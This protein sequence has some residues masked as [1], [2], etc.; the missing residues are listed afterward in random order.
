MAMLNK[1]VVNVSMLK[2]GYNISVI[3]IRL[4]GRGLYKYEFKTFR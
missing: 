4:G 2:I 1:M 3:N